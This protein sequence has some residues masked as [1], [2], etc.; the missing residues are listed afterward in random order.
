MDYETTLNSNKLEFRN[1]V[2]RALDSFQ[3]A[4]YYNAISYAHFAARNAWFNHPGLFF[5]DSLEKLLGS[6]SLIESNKITLPLSFTKRDSRSRILHIVSEMYDT[7]GHTRALLRWIENTRNF[8]NNSIVITRQVIPPKYVRDELSS[9]GVNY[10]SLLGNGSNVLYRAGIL[11][12]LTEEC[13]DYVILH[14]HP[15]DVVP[16]L[17]Y[18]KME[19]TPVLLFNHADHVFWLGSS[20]SDSILNIRDSALQLSVTR[21]G[22]NTNL[23][24]PIPLSIKNSDPVPNAKEKLGIKEKKVILTIAS[25]YKFSPM[26]S[27]NY[28]LFFSKF[29]EKRNDT[30]LVIVGGQPNGNLKILKSAFPSKV[31]LVSPTPFIDIYKLAADV[32]LDSFP[33]ASL[34]SCLD[35]AMNNLPV[36]RVKNNLIPIANSDDP[37]FDAF[38][39]NWVGIEEL[40]EK[41]VFFLENKSY[42]DEVGIKM[43]ESVLAKHTGSGWTDR[44][45]HSLNFTYKHN[46]AQNERTFTEE[47]Q[48]YD[49]FLTSIRTGQSSSLIWSIYQ[50]SLKFAY[51]HKLVNTAT[52]LEEIL[53]KAEGYRNK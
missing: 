32:Y 23:I 36:L 19:T 25:D 40:E 47:E 14:T 34:T 6:M 53:S 48:P 33:L 1:L 13:A 39:D 2:N 27:Y 18:S 16:I 49:K 15:D 50:K 51:Q 37:A 29:L 31:L 38:S 5:S 21:R 10:I 4:H 3:H 42:A 8:H 11:R 28:A 46:S 44:L 52:K 43:R 7:G 22:H 9:L 17:A 35:A 12:K 45:Q 20:I 24:L 26:D 41:L 30:I